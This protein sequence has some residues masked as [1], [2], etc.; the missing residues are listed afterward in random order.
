VWS[1]PDRNAI[2]A[3]NSSETQRRA[4]RDFAAHLARSRPEKTCSSGSADYDYSSHTVDMISAGFQVLPRFSAC[5][6]LNTWRTYTATRVFQRFFVQTERKFRITVSWD[7]SWSRMH[8]WGTL[9]F[10]ALS[11]LA[12]E[13]YSRKFSNIRVQRVCCRRWQLCL[14]SL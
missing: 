5:N 9:R 14:V 8:M 12:C 11:E 6:G 3:T 1:P 10:V 2:P 7:C 13:H 4:R